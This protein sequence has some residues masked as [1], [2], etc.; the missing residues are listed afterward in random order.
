MDLFTDIFN[1]AS[2]ILSF[3]QNIPN[4]LVQ[5]I[6]NFPPSLVTILIS[7]LIIIIAIR[8]IELLL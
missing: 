4:M 6:A 8:I 2:G 5:C 3:I 1:S 7:G